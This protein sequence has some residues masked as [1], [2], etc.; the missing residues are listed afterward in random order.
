M[1]HSDRLYASRVDMN[2]ALWLVLIYR[3]VK[4][5]DEFAGPLVWDNT[6]WKLDDFWKGE[7]LEKQPYAGIVTVYKVHSCGL[8]DIS[9]PCS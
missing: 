4:P 7:L 5:L 3:K 2:P 8:S 6:S 9:Y 1:K